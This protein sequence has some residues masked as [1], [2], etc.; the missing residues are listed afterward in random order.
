MAAQPVV[1]KVRVKKVTTERPEPAAI[2]IMDSIKNMSRIPKKKP[3]P[4]QQYELALSEDEDEATSV[5]SLGSA[6]TSAVNNQERDESSKKRKS[7]CLY[8][9]I[10]IDLTNAPGNRSITV[11][12]TDEAHADKFI[13]SD[14]L[15][16]FTDKSH[17]GG[18]V[19]KVRKWWLK[20]RQVEASSSGG[21]FYRDDIPNFITHL[22][23]VYNKW[24]KN[25]N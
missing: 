22:Q 3:E 5:V 21:E 12:Q 15:V 14:N 18:R 7:E 9:P 1:K 2:N 8:E 11:A 10:K 23:K 25:S 16:F 4:I 13:V 24:N 6:S 17:C 20:N 19:C